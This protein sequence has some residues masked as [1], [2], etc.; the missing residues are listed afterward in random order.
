MDKPFMSG[1]DK[2]SLENGPICPLGTAETRWEKS[3]WQAKEQ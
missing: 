3:C 1:W 2:P